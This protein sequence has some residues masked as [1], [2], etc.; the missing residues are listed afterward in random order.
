MG[1]MQVMFCVLPEMLVYVMLVMQE[2]LN[3]IT[4]QYLEAPQNSQQLERYVRE[5][6]QLLGL[7]GAGTSAGAK[8]RCLEQSSW[9]WLH[10]QHTQSLRV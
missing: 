10:M 9:R 2:K 4:K 5:C 3:S 7:R 8:V 1:W 6:A